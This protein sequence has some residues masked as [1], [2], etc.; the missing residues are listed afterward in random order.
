[1]CLRNIARIPGSRHSNL[2]IA[3]YSAAQVW[4]NPN[5]YVHHYHVHGMMW[6]ESQ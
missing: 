6:G 2:D 4:E 1:M 5:R 3:T